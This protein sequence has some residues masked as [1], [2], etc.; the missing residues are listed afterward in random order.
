MPCLLDCLHFVCAYYVH[1][2]ENLLMYR[3]REIFM[4]NIFHIKWINHIINGWKTCNIYIKNEQRFDLLN[5]IFWI[6]ENYYYFHSFT[7]WNWTSKW[8]SFDLFTWK[9][10][11]QQRRYELK[12]VL[13]TITMDTH[14]LFM[15]I[16]FWRF[17]STRERLPCPPYAVEQLENFQ[18]LLHTGPL[19]GIESNLE[20]VLWIWS[21]KKNKCWAFEQLL[22]TSL[23][24]VLFI[25]VSYCAITWCFMLVSRL[26]III[27]RLLEWTSRTWKFLF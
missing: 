3:V 26:L 19:F 17:F 10:I 4:K 23:H 16:N 6:W 21:N 5:Y 8:I 7:T 12:L 14:N 9:M 1:V 15:V 18:S 11:S 20:L 13:I 25:V 2:W 27:I 24:S 22:P